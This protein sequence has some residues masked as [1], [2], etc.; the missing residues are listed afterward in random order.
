M[1]CTNACNFPINNVLV[2]RLKVIF[3]RLVLKQYIFNNFK[4]FD[5]DVRQSTAAFWVYEN[6]TGSK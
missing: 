5:I 6:A 3:S 4:Y 1:P 2:L